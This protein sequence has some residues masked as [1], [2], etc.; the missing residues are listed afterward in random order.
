MVC[1]MSNGNGVPYVQREANENFLQVAHSLDLQNLGITV[2]ER[3]EF[4]LFRSC[5]SFFVLFCS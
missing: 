5:L 3:E 1:P 4:V 2:S